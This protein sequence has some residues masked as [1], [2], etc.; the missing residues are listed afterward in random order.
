MHRHWKAILAA[1]MVVAAV[2]AAALILGTRH[3][4]PAPEPVA[5]VAGGGKLGFPVSPVKIGAGGTGVSADGRTP[6]G[7]DGS[8]N[9]AA[10]A[11]ANFM[12]V[13][14]DV[15]PS[16]WPVQQKALAQIDV[17]ADELKDL[18]TLADL[19]AKNLNASGIRTFGGDWVTRTDVE[20]GGLYRMVSC[21]ERR[22]ALVQVVYARIDAQ[23]G[24]GPKASFVTQS[25]DLS[26]QGGDWKVAR[27]QPPLGDNGTLGGR[28][29]DRGPNLAALP[30]P[31]GKPPVL[32]K[33]L[34]NQAFKDVSREGWIDY[35][36]AVR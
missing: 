9:S 1:A 8:C 2:T 18:A 16:A 13:I 14:A 35:A 24:A 23:T 20:S 22:S 36:N 12:P 15:H 27:S 21:T 6:V 33:D 29:P 5:T 28:L 30:A 7:Y 34:A 4:Q 17:N 11:A 31:E 26:W 25:L 3:D 10:A 19:E 32:T